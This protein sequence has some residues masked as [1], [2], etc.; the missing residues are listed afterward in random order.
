MNE[1]TIFVKSL[2]KKG[3]LFERVERLFQCY[4]AL[5]IHNFDPTCRFGIYC[6]VNLEVAIQFDRFK[7]TQK[8]SYAKVVETIPK[9]TGS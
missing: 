3:G 5:C 2:Y 8:K 9:K 7:K 1:N 4:E 6:R